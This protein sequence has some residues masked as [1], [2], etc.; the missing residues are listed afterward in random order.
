MKAK[1]NRSNGLTSFID[2]TTREIKHLLKGNQRKF[3]NSLTNDQRSALV[4]LSR[5]K[6][7]V[8][9]Q[10]DKRGVLVIMVMDSNKCNEACLQQLADN[11]Y[12]FAE[13][14]KKKTGKERK[15]GSSNS[16]LFVKSQEPL[17]RR[18]KTMKKSMMSQI[19]SIDKLSK[20]TKLTKCLMEV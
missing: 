6:N 16:P 20:L 7:I 13:L 17:R 4:R 1:E 2:N 12:S 11:Q 10:V 3:W 8:I 9:K 14:P 18:V 19:S 5:D 15:G